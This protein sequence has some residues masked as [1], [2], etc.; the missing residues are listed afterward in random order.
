MTT[1]TEFYIGLNGKDMKNQ[2]VAPEQ[3]KDTISEMVLGGTFKQAE[4]L[5]MGD[6]ENTLVFE[7]ADLEGSLTEQF[8]EAYVDGGTEKVFQ[9]VKER[10]ENEFN[11]ESVMVKQVDADIHF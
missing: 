3:V 8:K 4:G 7:V 1:L 10:L 6:F 11:Q 9:L 5:W 2:E